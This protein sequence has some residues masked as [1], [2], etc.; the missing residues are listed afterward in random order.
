MFKKNQINIQIVVKNYAILIMNDNT[1]E[2][3]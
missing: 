2:Q 3:Y 1:W